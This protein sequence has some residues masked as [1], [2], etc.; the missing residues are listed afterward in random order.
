MCNCNG[1]GSGKRSNLGMYTVPLVGT[2]A[3]KLKRVIASRI[4][5]MA[6]APKK[7]MV[8]V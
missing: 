5:F 4:V 6:N 2:Q 7:L 3:A 8:H 1:T